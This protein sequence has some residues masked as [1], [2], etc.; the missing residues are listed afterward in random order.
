MTGTD[1]H[2]VK[3]LRDLP[4]S[5]E[6]PRDLWPQIEARLKAETAAVP[7]ATQSARRRGGAP[8]RWF[9]AAAMVASVGVG[10]WIGRDVLPIPG[11]GSRVTPV[12]AGN[13]AGATSGGASAV[14]AAYVS[15]PR[16]RRERAHLVQSVQAQLDAMPPAARAK[17][18]AG[19][20]NEVEE[21]NQ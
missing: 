10:V 8:A 19:L 11:L 21:V 2:K 15:D 3:S 17:V 16:Y 7:S 18:T 5:I 9:A 1:E 4:P 12:T 20:A 14:D 6:P 13:H